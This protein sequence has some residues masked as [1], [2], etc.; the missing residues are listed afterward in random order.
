MK[1]ILFLCT[2]MA[3]MLGL[4]AQNQ[5]QGKRAAYLGDSMTDLNNKAANYHYYDYLRDSLGIEPLVYARSGNQWHQVYKYAERMIKEQGDNIDVI[6]IWAGTNDYF[7]STPIGQFYTEHDTVVN[8]NGK[9]V[10]RKGRY[11]IYDDTTFCGRINKLLQMLKHRYPTQQII[12]MTPPHRAYANFSRPERANV[13]P[14]ENISN[15]HGLY[16]EDYVHVLKQAGEYWSVPVVDLFSTS[17][18]YPLDDSYTRYFAN[19][20]TDRLHP[21]NQGH[22]RLGKT[23]AEKIKNLPSRF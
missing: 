13:Q 1:R 12:L 18:L 7:H 20:D 15:E 8:V 16:I 6:F 17:G 21:N 9:M 11:W 4:V 10:P 23:I 19:P 3:S 14:D 22:I 5:W 2:L